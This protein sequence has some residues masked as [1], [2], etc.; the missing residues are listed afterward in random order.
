MSTVKGNDWMVECT[1]V[2][3]RARVRFRAVLE[4][5]RRAGYPLCVVEVYRSP[6]KQLKLFLAGRTPLRYPIYHGRGRAMDCAFVVNG[7]ITWAVSEEWWKCYGHHA[8]ANGLTWGGDWR[9][10]KCDRPHVQYRGP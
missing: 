10:R 4:G 1:R 3:P 2:N 9:G 5:V 8:R 6:A 7:R